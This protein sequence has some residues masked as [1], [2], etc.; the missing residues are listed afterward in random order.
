MNALLGEDDRKKEAGG[1]ILK[2]VSRSLQNKST[3]A[4]SQSSKTTLPSDTK[5]KK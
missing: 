5:K 1:K 2:N 4:K 3:L